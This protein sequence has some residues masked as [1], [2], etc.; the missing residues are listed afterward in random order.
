MLPPAYESCDSHIGPI[1]RTGLGRKHN[2]WKMAKEKE[3]RA[4]VLEVTV[5]P[6][7]PRVILP[8]DFLLFIEATVT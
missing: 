2:V 4:L 8:L 7:S 1:R 5:E 3:E 6:T